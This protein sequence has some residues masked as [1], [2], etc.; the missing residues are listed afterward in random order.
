MVD[1]A[2]R[3][4]VETVGHS[5]MFDQPGAF[6]KTQTLIISFV[7][8]AVGAVFAQ[9]AMADSTATPRVDR[10]E[11]RQQERISQGVA[12]GQLTPKETAH[13]QAASA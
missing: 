2:A 8:T 13:L 6:M 12:S 4:V 9:S 7:L 3:R 10:R 1:K 11:A 5:T